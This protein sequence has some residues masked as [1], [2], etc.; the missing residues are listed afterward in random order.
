MVYRHIVGEAMANQ[1]LKEYR[2]RQYF[3]DA[4]REI[5]DTEG[6]K[7]I[8]IRKIAEKAGFNSATIY[9]Y[10]EDLSHLI[11]FAAMKYLKEYTDDLPNYMSR[12]TNAL[13]EYLQI[14][15]CFCYHSFK[16]PQ[17]YFILFASNLGHLPENI[18]KNYYTSFPDEINHLPPELLPMLLESDLTRRTQISLKKCLDE[19]W[20]DPLDAEA[21][22]ERIVAIYLGMLTAYLN[23]RVRYTAEEAVTRTMEHIRTM[24][25]QIAK[26]HA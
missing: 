9:N 4:A 20:I 16:S 21:V 23:H 10:F 18:V 17:I 11:F 13:D 15:E 6:L 19:G 3:I 25:Y 22:T 26:K 14:W 24:L 8:T 12:A 1:A 7:K 2:M 5:I